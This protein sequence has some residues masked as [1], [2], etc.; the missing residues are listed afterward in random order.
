MSWKRPRRKTPLKE[1][2]CPED[3]APTGGA[4]FTGTHKLPGHTP[5][6]VTVPFVEPPAAELVRIEEAAATEEADNAAEPR[7][8]TCRHGRISVRATRPRNLTRGTTC[9]EEPPA[10]TPQGRRPTPRP[11]PKGPSDRRPAD[12]VKQKNAGKQDG[13]GGD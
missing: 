7:G 10:E 13:P 9:S 8:E 4:S 1:L 5:E 3:F 12:T 6:R 11:K 2:A